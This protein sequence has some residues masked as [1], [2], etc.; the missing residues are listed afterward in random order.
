MQPPLIFGRNL[1][2]TI[3]IPLR[4]KATAFARLALSS[5]EEENGSARRHLGHRRDNACTAILNAKKERYTR[6]DF[7][8]ECRW[9]LDL[10]QSYIWIN[11]D[12]LLAAPEVRPTPLAA[13][14]SQ[15]CMTSLEQ[16]VHQS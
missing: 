2:T 12:M 10:C 15:R 4:P 8:S 11:T 14:M 16:T 1:E 7:N 9:R 3:K 6:Y 5:V 13:Q